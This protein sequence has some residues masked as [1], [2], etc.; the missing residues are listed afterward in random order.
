LSWAAEFQYAFAGRVG[1]VN[2]LVDVLN[3]MHW[4]SPV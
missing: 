1:I 2:G 3:L 4:A